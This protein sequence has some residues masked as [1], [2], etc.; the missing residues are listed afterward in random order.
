MTYLGN[1]NRIS[2]LNSSTATLNS[3]DTFTGTA[4]D[5]HDVNSVVMAVKTDQDGTLY[6]QFS[7]DGTNWDSSLTFTVLANTNE[8]HRL[9]VTRR[10]FRI[11][12]TNSSA[13]N[14]TFFRLETMF[15]GQSALTST[16]NSTIQSDAD[17][18]TVRPLD[19]N[20]M[21]AEGLYENRSNTI[22]DGVNDDIDTGSVPEDIWNVGGTYTGFPVTAPENGEV[23][24]SGAD[25]GRVYY[26]YLAS[27]GSTDYVFGNVAIAGAGTYSLGHNVW[28]CNFMYFVANSSTAFNVGTI[29]LRHSITT[30]NVFC[31]I[32]IGYSQ[33][34]C[35][36]YTVPYG[37]SVYLDRVAGN[38][39]GS[40]SGYMDGYFWFRS[41]NESPKL[42]FPFVLQFGALFFDDIDYLVKIPAGT[43]FIPRVVASSANNLAAQVSYRLIKTK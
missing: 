28:R 39:R 9:V 6:G 20:L 29:T 4:E 42:R 13:S 3:G 33:S 37:S 43:D 17:A 26:S 5:V 2:T 31:Q 41:L 38:L 10:Y 16:L 30:T 23:V 22:K 14:Q 27:S 34:Y 11:V 36:A 8:V 1:R 24:V 7:N 15:G 25:T 35:S 21:V 40:T 32:A 18:T 19:F 12:F